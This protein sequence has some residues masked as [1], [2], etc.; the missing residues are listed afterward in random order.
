MTDFAFVSLTVTA[1]V[2]VYTA[3]RC[4]CGRWLMDV[5]GTVVP[6]VRPIED[7]RQRQRGRALSC[8]RCS[9]LVEVIE[10]AA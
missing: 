1:S 3:V 4:G 8:P 6:E 7:R 5:P 2:V 9:A 10:H